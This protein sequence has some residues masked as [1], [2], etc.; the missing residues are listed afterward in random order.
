MAGEVEDV[1]VARPQTRFDAALQVRAHEPRFIGGAHVVDDQVPRRARGQF[2]KVLALLGHGLQRPELHRR[3]RGPAVLAPEGDGAE[4]RTGVHEQHPHRLAGRARVRL[5]ARR[6]RRAVQMQTPRHR[7]FQAQVT[8]AVGAEL[9]AH[10]K[11]Q[12]EQARHLLAGQVEFEA[13]V[14]SREGPRARRHFLVA[15]ALDQLGDRRAQTMGDH[16]AEDVLAHAAQVFQPLR[17]LGLA[18]IGTEGLDTAH[19]RRDAVALL[20]RHVLRRILVAPHL[21]AVGDRVL[22]HANDQPPPALGRKRRQAGEHGGY[23]R[24][25]VDVCL[26]IVGPHEDLGTFQHIALHQFGRVD[27]QHQQ[28]D[29]RA[30]GDPFQQFHGCRAGLAAFAGRGAEPGVD[31]DEPGFDAGRGHVP[32][33]ELRLGAFQRRAAAQLRADER[34]NRGILLHKAMQLGKVVG[35][36]VLVLVVHAG[37]QNEIRSGGVVFHDGDSMIPM[38]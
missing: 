9:A 8:A 20:V 29:R 3:Q 5:P 36:V 33:F 35:P 27:R 15:R 14:Q 21:D 13:Q 1:V 19:Q 2:R 4:H 7:Q 16:G 24:A 34:C 12:V 25:A 17:R 23:F 31:D 30:R 6:G 38:A 28:R 37:Q 10:L 32:R 22:A 11:G 18:Q 26:R